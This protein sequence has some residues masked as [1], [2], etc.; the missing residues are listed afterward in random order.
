MEWDDLNSGMII[1][2]NADFVKDFDPI[3][4][5][6]ETRFSTYN[7]EW[8]DTQILSGTS[9]S[10]FQYCALLTS[11]QSSMGFT[12]MYRYNFEKYK[13]QIIIS[14]KDDIQFVQRRMERHIFSYKMEYKRQKS[15]AEDLIQKAEKFYNC[16]LEI[17]ETS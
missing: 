16:D 9:Y 2:W 15:W 17:K 3:I 11:C 8:F 4:I 10:A 1:R 5:I 6:L 14:E 12:K 7:R 13:N